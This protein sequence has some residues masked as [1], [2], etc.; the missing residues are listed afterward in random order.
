M[1]TDDLSFLPRVPFS[2]RIFDLVLTIPGLILISPILLLVSLAV[3]FAHGWPILFTQLRPGYAGRPFRIHKFRTMTNA[4]DVNGNLLPDAQRLTRLGRFLRASSLD[5]LPALI[6]VLRGEMSLV[7]P[8]PLLMQYLERYSPEQARRHHALPG[9]T[10]WAQ[11]NGRNA[12]TWQEKFRLDVWYVD[13][14][15]L[16]LDIKILLLTFWKTLRREGISQPG[17]ATAEEFLGNEEDQP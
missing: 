7:G 11:I 15:S 14:W 6:N 3:W 16:I 17:H 8:R 12:I 9:I 2:K 1:P 13:H 4:R 5:E 10:G